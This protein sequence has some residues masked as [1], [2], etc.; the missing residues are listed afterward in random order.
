MCD[1]KLITR[2]VSLLTDN[3]LIVESIESATINLAG[4]YCVEIENESLFKLKQ[5]AFVIA[6]FASLKELCDFVKQDMLLNGA[7]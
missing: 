7:G 1:E 4:G 2:I 5:D 6:P 3:D